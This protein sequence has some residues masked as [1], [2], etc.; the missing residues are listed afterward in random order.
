MPKLG[1]G[2]SG[3]LDRA[4]IGV[5]CTVGGGGEATMLILGRYNQRG[6]LARKN[7]KV[8][9]CLSFQVTGSGIKCSI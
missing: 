1:V 9:M 5:E 2:Y 6:G 3:N 4:R 7:K 8:A